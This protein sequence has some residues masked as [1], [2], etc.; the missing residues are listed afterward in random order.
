[1]ILAHRMPFDTCWIRISDALNEDKMK[2]QR[3][4]L[5]GFAIVYYDTLPLN[6]IIQ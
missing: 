6:I 3:P 2:K 4:G 5:L 1:M